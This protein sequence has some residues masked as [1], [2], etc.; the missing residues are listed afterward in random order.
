MTTR[1]SLIV[2]E[3]IDGGRASAAVFPACVSIR[4]ADV[5]VVFTRCYRGNKLGSS[6]TGGT[7]IRNCHD[8]D[9]HNVAYHATVGTM[10]EGR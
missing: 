3:D 5:G 4:H 1:E 8:T 2:R 6:V 9:I 10:Q 7:Y